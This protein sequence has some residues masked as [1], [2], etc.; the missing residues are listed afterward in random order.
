MF[1]MLA[2]IRVSYPLLLS[3]GDIMK[4]SSSSGDAK[5]LSSKQKS[6]TT[7]YIFIFI[8]M[9]LSFYSI[10]LV[11][12]F[13]LI[14]F[15]LLLV[16]LFHFFKGKIATTTKRLK[17][18]VGLLII[19][20]IG[21]LIGDVI[22]GT[23]LKSMLKG[24]SLILFTLINLYGV[25]FLTKFRPLETK[26]ALLG[27][28]LGGL[29]GFFLQPTTYARSEI[30]KFGIGYPITLTVLLLISFPLSGGF[31]FLPVISLFLLSVVSLSLGARSLAL[32][33]L[34]TLFFSNYKKS[35]GDFKNSRIVRTLIII[36]I[37]TFAFSSLYSRLAVNGSLGIK[38]QSKYL[39]QT[40][41]GGNLVINSRSELI[42]AASGIAD[43]PLFGQGSYAKMNSEL[44][45]KTLNLLDS[46][47][48][49]FDL[50][51]LIRTYGDRIPVHSMLLQ[52]WLW[53]GALGM[54]F[55]L[56]LSFLYFKSLS[57]RNREPVFYY[58][59]LSGLWNVLLSPYGESFRILI[60]L[61]IVTLLSL[62]NSSQ[63][64]RA[65]DE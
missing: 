11:G 26:V 13:L 61:T 49:H 14:E 57:V 35:K 9:F 4:I 19:A 12:R 44:S 37:V 59:A 2:L 22:S 55:P 42:F 28:S 62:G 18:F 15:L 63:I 25:S 53:F 17:P 5:D 20:I 1:D 38:A 40:S 33:V 27:Y 39:A 45:L 60:P 50:A 7:R 58:L 64:D 31:R 23:E 47:G 21:Q 54:L 32:L 52:W 48:I 41:A 16:F 51:P 43:S 10:N 36:S 8:I 65:S 34:L 24:F 3:C 29:A 30:W 56:R 46:A 6:H